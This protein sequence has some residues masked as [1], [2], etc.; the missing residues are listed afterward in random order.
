MTIDLVKTLDMSVWYHGTESERL[1]FAKEL[2]RCF[3][4]Q[5]FVKLV[6]HPISEQTMERAFELVSKSARGRIA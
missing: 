4:R 6:N 5:G 2:F 1:S 3:S